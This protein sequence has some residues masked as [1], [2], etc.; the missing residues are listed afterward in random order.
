MTSPCGALLF[1]CIYSFIKQKQL[2]VS[3]LISYTTTAGPMKMFNSFRPWG[4]RSIPTMFECALSCGNSKLEQGCQQHS[5][6]RS[7]M[8]HKYVVST[9]CGRNLTGNFWNT[10]LLIVCSAVQSNSL[11]D[12]FFFLLN[13]LNIVNDDLCLTPVCSRHCRLWSRPQSSQYWLQVLV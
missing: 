9:N 5:N 12:C 11:F 3:I 13:K 1:Y 2:I 10:S 6:N 7:S 4:R 8:T